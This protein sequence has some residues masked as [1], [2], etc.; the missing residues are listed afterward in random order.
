MET[1]NGCIQEHKKWF[2]KIVTV[3][4]ASVIKRKKVDVFVEQYIIYYKNI[5]YYEMNFSMATGF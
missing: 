1:R 5:I 2:V 3:I 4:I